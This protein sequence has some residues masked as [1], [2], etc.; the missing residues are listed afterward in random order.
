MMPNGTAKKN[1][2][3]RLKIYQGT[4]HPHKA[5]NPIFLTNIETFNLN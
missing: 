3:Q 2:G 1:L 5:Q 4:E